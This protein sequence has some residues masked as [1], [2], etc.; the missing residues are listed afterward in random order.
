MEQSIYEMVNLDSFHFKDGRLEILV[1]PYSFLYAEYAA[2][3]VLVTLCV[4]LGK[5]METI[6]K[7]NTESMKGNAGRP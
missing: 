2:A 4:L 3:T 6:P 5:V 7:V 1:T